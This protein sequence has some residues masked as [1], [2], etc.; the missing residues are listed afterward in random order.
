MNSSSNNPWYLDKS[1]K[2]M[3]TVIVTMICNMI[4]RKYGYSLNT[5]EI[6]GI[7]SVVVAFIGGHKWHSSN[8]VKVNAEIEKLRVGSVSGIDPESIDVALANG[9]EKEQLEAL[10]IL[11]QKGMTK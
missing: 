8:E 3:L 7:I 9:T 2:A 11:L 4:G 10:K 6:V 1:F 5:E